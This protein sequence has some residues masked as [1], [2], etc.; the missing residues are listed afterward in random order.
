VAREC[1]ARGRPADA[2]GRRHHGERRNLSWALLVPEPGAYD[3]G[4]LDRTLDLLLGNGIRVGLATPTVVPPAWFYRAHPD[5]L[6]VSRKGVRYSFGSG[7]A[8]CHSS[9]PHRAAAAVITTK[10]AERYAGHPALALW[11]VHNE[12]GVPVSAACYCDTC[13]AHFRR[14]LDGR[15]GSVDAVNEAWGTAFWGRRYTSYEQIDPP[16]VTPTVG[17]P[18]QQLDYRRFTDATLRES[19]VG[20]RDILHRLCSG[21]PVTTNFMTALSQC[22]AVD[23]WAWGHEVDLV[24]NDHRRPPHPR[25]PGDGRRPDPL[26]GRRGSLTAPQPRQ[27]P[28]RDGPQLPRPCG[29]RLRVTEAREPGRNDRSCRTENEERRTRERPGSGLPW[30]RSR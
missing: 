7:G 29:P 14:W 1:L 24:T 22:D 16:R 4:W 19:F 23:Y 27:P 20:E 12:Y 28:G 8:I 6:P 5:A 18:A 10:L 15:Y 21:V 11:H 30:R 25:Q 2:G 9:P 17:N 13:A 3:F 26:G